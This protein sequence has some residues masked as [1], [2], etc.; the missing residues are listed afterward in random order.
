M[1]FTRA[2]AWE[3]TS[4]GV[5]GKTVDCGNSSIVG[6]KMSCSAGW[7]KGATQWMPNRT[8]AHGILSNVSTT[9]ADASEDGRL[10]AE[11]TDKF[12]TGALAAAAS[13]EPLEPLLPDDVLA[14]PASGT[15][16][17]ARASARGEAALRAGHVAAL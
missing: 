2:G 12:R 1:R 11:L 7:R 5:C 15:P 13:P 16:E 3:T 6:P 14:L 10:F 17:H 8:S 4:G 9:G